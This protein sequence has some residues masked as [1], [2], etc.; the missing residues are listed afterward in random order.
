MWKQK[1]TLPTLELY[2]DGA[3]SGNPG[4]G[5]YAYV[6]LDHN[7]KVVESRA[8]ALKIVTNFIAEYTAILE[9]LRSIIIADGCVNVV[10]Y[11]DAE[12]VVN[13]LNGLAQV[14]ADHLKRFVDLISKVEEQLNTVVYRHV[15]NTDGMI[16]IVD[17][18]AKQVL[19]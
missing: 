2:T 16:K 5:S 3:C 19:K 9:G 14:K 11:C 13:Q 7:Q 4:P 15:P 17:K 1:K 10:V 8:R 12:V 6:I 18:M